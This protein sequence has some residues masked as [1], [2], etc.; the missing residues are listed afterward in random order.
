MPLTAAVKLRERMLPGEFAYVALAG[1]TI[2]EGGLVALNAAGTLQRIQTAG[3]VVFA[4]IADGTRINS[5][6]G[7]DVRAVRCR[8]GIWQLNV[9]GAS[10]AN[11]GQTVYATDDATVVLG[12]LSVAAAASGSNHGNGTFTTGPTLGA[13]AKPGQYLLT[14]TGA[15]TFTMVDPNGDALPAGAALA[16]Y[17]DAAMSFSITAGTNAFQAGDTFTFT[18]AETG[19]GLP[20]GTLAGIDAGQTYVRLTGSN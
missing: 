6:A 18:V 16:G 4:G 8:K 15:T 1:E 10:P 17:A 9:A 2:Y 12:G 20:I 5:P 14:F 11:V 3:S 19:G 7:N 13:G